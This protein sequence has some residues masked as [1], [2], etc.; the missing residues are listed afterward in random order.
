[1][2]ALF[3]SCFCMLLRKSNVTPDK[4]W[5]TKYMR[6]EHI[7]RGPVGYLVSLYWTKTIQTGDRRLEFPLLEAPGCLLC[8]VWALDNMIKLNPAAKS[9]P[10]FCHSDRTPLKS[11]TFNNFLKSKIRN[12]GMSPVGWS[13]H[14]FRHGRTTYLAACGASEHQIQI[15]GDWKS[16]CFKKYIHCPWQDK[17]DIANKMHTHMILGDY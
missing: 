7:W 3:L 8:P 6:R 12:L 15:L 13:T 11:N 17:L 10:A 9:D 16:D 4:E 1:M 14:S 2:W 5:E